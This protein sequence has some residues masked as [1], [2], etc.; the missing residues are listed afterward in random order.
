[1]PLNALFIIYCSPFQV[2]HPNFLNYSHRQL[3]R[4]LHLQM[5]SFQ[6]LTHQSITLTRR[7]DGRQKWMS[8]CRWWDISRASIRHGYKARGYEAEAKPKLWLNHKAEVEA[9]AKPL[10][11]GNCQAEPEA[12]LFLAHLCFCMV[13]SYPSLCVCPSVTGPNQKLFFIAQSWNQS[14]RVR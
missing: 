9:E 11:F 7:Q 12:F 6:R 10:T 13:G 4:F 2:N 14:L 5:I 3:K 8:K 1:M